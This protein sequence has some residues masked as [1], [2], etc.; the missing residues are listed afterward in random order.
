MRAALAGL[1]EIDWG[2]LHPNNASGSEIP[3]LLRAWRDGV[4]FEAVPSRD[5]TPYRLT[6]MLLHQ[7]TRFG[8][9]AEALP[10][11]LELAAADET[12]QRAQLI[13][14]AAGIGAPD[15]L[16]DVLAETEE[17]HAELSLA[18]CR[19]RQA[20]TGML[21]RARRRLAERG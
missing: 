21:A 10:F 1:H 20:L 2:T 7:G 12:P 8:G 5:S 11:L 13:Y 17:R 18:D 6:D 4:G 9:A 16:V 3:R 19:F 15:D 14:F